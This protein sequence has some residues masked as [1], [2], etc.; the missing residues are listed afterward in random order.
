MVYQRLNG[1]LNQTRGFIAHL[2]VVERGTR[3]V[4]DSA[5]HIEPML[6]VGLL[7]GV[8]VAATHPG[9]RLAVYGRSN[10]K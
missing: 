1:T 3:L 4:L 5:A 9:P 8:G 6:F 7:P 10:M 2:S